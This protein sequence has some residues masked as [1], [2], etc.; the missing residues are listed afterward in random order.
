M[1]RPSPA[2]SISV[3]CRSTAPHGALPL[4]GAPTV[5]R[6]LGV[7]LLDAA[8]AVSRVPGAGMLDAASAVPRV[9]GATPEHYDSRRLHPI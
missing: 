9:T 4:D 1:R 5:P 2:H 8:P 6:V 7:S 3:P